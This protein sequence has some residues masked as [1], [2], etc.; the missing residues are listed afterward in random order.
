MAELTYLYVAYTII[1]AG[2][3]LYILKL[4]MDQKKLK[5]ELK[6]LREVIHGRKQRKEKDI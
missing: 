3:F 2:S 6:V 1:W 5:R 4:H